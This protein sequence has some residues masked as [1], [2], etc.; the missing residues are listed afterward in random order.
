MLRALL[1]L[2]SVELSQLPHS[3]LGPH[4]YLVSVLPVGRKLT[5][6]FLLRTPPKRCGTV[7]HR[8]Y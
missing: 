2:C 5:A 6:R 1:A 8:K 7:N 4:C 3:S